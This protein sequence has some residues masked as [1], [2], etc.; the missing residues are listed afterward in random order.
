L[1]KVVAGCLAAALLAPP[2]FAHHSGA[3][4]DR[5]KTVTVSGTV[6]QFLYVQPHSWID[7]V[8]VGADGQQTEWSFEAGTPGQMKMVSLAPSTLKP[9]DK[10]TIKGYPLRDGRHGGAFL[11]ITMPDGK[12][13]VTGRKPPPEQTSAPAPAS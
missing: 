8:S 4:Y 13:I 12:V 2:A 11:Q 6:K 7:V 9:G 1:D 5:Q 10:V 3:M